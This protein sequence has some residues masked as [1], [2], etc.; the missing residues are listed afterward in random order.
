MD[1]DNDG[2]LSFH[3]IAQVLS[4]YFGGSEDIYRQIWNRHV[5]GDLEYLTLKHLQDILTHYPEYAALYQLATT[6]NPDPAEGK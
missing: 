5:T 1:V 6:S 3:D 4:R 2:Q